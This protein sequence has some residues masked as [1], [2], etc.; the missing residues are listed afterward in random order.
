MLCDKCKKNNATVHITRIVN[1]VMQEEHLCSQCA[2]TAGQIFAPQPIGWQNLFGGFQNMPEPEQ[3][4]CPQCGMTYRDFRQ[5]GKMG[6][7]QCYR[8]FSGQVPKLLESIHGS[9]HHR[10][11][12]PVAGGGKTSMVGQLAAK[13]QQLE[14][15]VAQEKF[16]E[17]AVLRDEIKALEEKGGEA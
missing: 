15:L 9:S 3:T 8:A 4:R 12:I 17:A 13:K 11:K 16:E 10:G 14:A 5:K 7:P 6:C 1:G 2:G